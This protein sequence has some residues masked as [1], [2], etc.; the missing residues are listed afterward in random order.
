M[1]PDPTTFSVAILAGGQASRLGGVDK[2]A[3]RV[4]GRSILERELAVARE[5][6]TNILIVAADPTRFLDT[7]VRVETDRIA[8]AGALGGLYTALATAST[9]LV[10][11]LAC[12][13]PF[14]TSSFL[15]WMVEQAA[16]VD[17]VIPRD[18]HGRHPLCG[19]Y[20]VHAAPHVRACIEAGRRRVDSALDGL[21][22]RDIG[23]EQLAPHDPDGQLLLNVNTPDDYARATG[24]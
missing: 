8:G 7:G 11:V 20:A 22:V 19:V 14:V 3:L 13:M 24:R 6:T 9:N 4:N 15:A 21:S 17:A 10:L 23:P 12:D 1:T 18:Q 16:G 5:L 2:S